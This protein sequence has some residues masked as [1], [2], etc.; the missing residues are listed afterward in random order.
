MPKKLKHLLLFESLRI[1]NLKKI[2][3]TFSTWDEWSA[4]IINQPELITITRK[5]SGISAIIP[6]LDG[7]FLKGASRL[8]GYYYDQENS[9]KLC[10]FIPGKILTNTIIFRL[11][12]ENFK[13]DEIYYIESDRSGDQ[14]EIAANQEAEL[15]QRVKEPD[16]QSMMLQQEPNL[17][18]E[19]FNLLID[20]D[21]EK[22]IKRFGGLNPAS[23]DPKI[24][25]YGI[26]QGQESKEITKRLKVASLLRRF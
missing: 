19:A 7:E 18:I 23:I 4:W 5:I 25:E 2:F 16:F 1:L 8:W 20:G 21:L 17:V 10:V 12:F 15:N 26:T 9:Y 6:N 22:Y 3:Y 13:A 14:Y 24:I 11:N